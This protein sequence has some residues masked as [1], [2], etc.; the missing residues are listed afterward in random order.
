MTFCVLLSE[1]KLDFFKGKSFILAEIKRSFAFHQILTLC[2]A[3]MAIS[4]RFSHCLAIFVCAF[5]NTEPLQC[6]KS[7]LL[8]KLGLLATLMLDERTSIFNNDA[9]LTISRRARRSIIPKPAMPPP[10]VIKELEDI[11]KLKDEDPKTAHAYFKKR[12]LE[13]A[14]L[15]FPNCKRCTL[16][17]LLVVK[18]N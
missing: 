1:S 16:L 3:R 7:T 6:S 13:N 10:E 14:S 5:G 8:F 9:A 18:G 4:F 12:S 15:H 17:L 11:K 2:S